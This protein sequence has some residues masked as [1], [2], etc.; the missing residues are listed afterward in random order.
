M[1]GLALGLLRPSRGHAGQQPLQIAQLWAGVK[2]WYTQ[3]PLKVCFVAKECHEKLFAS[4]KWSYVHCGASPVTGNVQKGKQN[5]ICTA[6][7]QG[8]SDG[9]AAAHF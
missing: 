6:I 1:C 3:R 7:V 8:T 5:R 4:D 2:P 9:F